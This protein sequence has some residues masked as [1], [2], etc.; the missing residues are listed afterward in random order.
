MNNPTQHLPDWITWEINHPL[1]MGGGRNNQMI[2]IGPTLIRLGYT[3][4]QLIEIFNNMYSD[5]GPEQEREIASICRNSVKIAARESADFDPKKF[6][7]RKQQA[8]RIA[9]EMRQQLRQIL[10]D[11]EWPYKKIRDSNEWAF[12]ALCFQRDAFLKKMFAPADTIWIGEKW[13]SG[14]KRPQNASHFRTLEEWLRLPLI[15]WEFVSHSTFAPGST[16]RCNDSIAERKYLVVESD[17][18]TTD[19][20]G[21][22]FAYLDDCGLSL[23]AVVSSGGKSLHGWFPWPGE[24]YIEDW[25][26]ALE[27]LQCDVSTIRPSQPVR[28]PGIVRRNTGRP[29]ELLYLA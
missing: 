12:R 19:Q 16:C 27:G 22:V 1:A 26:A 25:A 29:Q 21:A 5:L 10:I 15:P 20:I 13:H 11:Y 3:E 17:E 2:R 6:R 4:E 28:L 9:L 8:E 23:Q 7:R 18:L 14:D 24:A